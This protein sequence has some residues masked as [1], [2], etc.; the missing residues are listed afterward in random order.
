M[1]DLNVTSAAKPLTRQQIYHYAFPGRSTSILV[2]T[3][4]IE[5]VKGVDVWVNAENT[6][7]Q[8]A[9]FYDWSISSVIR[10]LG[11]KRDATGRVATSADDLIANEL[12]AIMDG[13]LSVSGGAVIA[14]TAGELTASHGVKAIFHA[15]AVQGQ[16]GVGYR[17]VENVA[18]CVT[19]ALQLMD[20]DAFRAKG[21]TSIALPLL[22]AGARPQQLGTIV[23]DLF[24]TAVSDIER[25]PGTRIERICFLPW[26][27]LELET[28][29]SQLDSFPEL[30]HRQTTAGLAHPMRRARSA[31]S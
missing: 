21:L 11:A 6:N 27:T 15:A 18:S 12:A 14:T 17:P 22:S 10:Y 13:R 8:M 31:R 16:V 1:L 23:H 9:R 7:M 25:T 24:E 2:V 4:G 30:S 28:C 26:T 3:G 29:L 20:S 19:N 5:H